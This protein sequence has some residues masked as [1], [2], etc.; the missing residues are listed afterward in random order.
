MS[1]SPA[2]LYG[3]GQAT[4]SV[5]TLVTAQANAKTLLTKA[6]FTNL[7]A[8]VRLLTLYLVRAGAAASSANTLI[9]QKT[10]AA[11]ASYEADE[12]E[13]QILTAGDLIQWKADAAGV[14]NCTGVSGFVVT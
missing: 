13:G 11:G 8:A 2:V 6:V 1:L 7:D 3:G 12:L 10:L 9:Y 5:A 14:V 4:T